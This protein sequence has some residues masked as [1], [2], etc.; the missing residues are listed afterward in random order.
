MLDLT[1]D[2]LVQRKGNVQVGQEA[3]VEIHRKVVF[4]GWVRVQSW[5]VGDYNRSINNHMQK[6]CGNA[7]AI[8]RETSNDS[9]KT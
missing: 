3:D 6:C 4:S 5:D 7:D 2:M 8:S 9:S 1:K